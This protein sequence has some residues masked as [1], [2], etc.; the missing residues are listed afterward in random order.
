MIILNDD[1][2]KNEMLDKVVNLTNMMI[3]IWNDD[4]TKN[5]MLD[6]VVDLTNMAIIIWNDDN[7]MNEMLDNVANLTTMM[8]IWKWLQKQCTSNMQ[9][10]YEW[11]EHHELDAACLTIIRLAWFA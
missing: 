1:N 4:N 6:K 9:R 5:E 10:Y 7:T 3:I 8:M 2:T 11:G